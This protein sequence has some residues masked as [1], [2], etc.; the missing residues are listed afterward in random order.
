MCIQLSCHV[1]CPI[2]HAP[3]EFQIHLAGEKVAD[4]AGRNVE[5]LWS[6][7]SNMRVENHHTQNPG[8]SLQTAARIFDVVSLVRSAGL[9]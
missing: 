2:M 1:L 8:R 3:L 5:L 6:G 7:E 9:S 4:I